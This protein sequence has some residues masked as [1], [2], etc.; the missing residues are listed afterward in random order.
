MNVINLQEN[1]ETPALPFKLKLANRANI[2][3]CFRDGKEHTVSE[4]SQMTGI[5]KITTMRAVQ[6]FCEKNVLVTGGK[7][8]QHNTGGKYPEIFR[9]NIRKNILSI[10]LWPG[11]ICLTL[12]DFSGQILYRRENNSVDTHHVSVQEIEAVLKEELRSFFEESKADRDLIY[13]VALSTAGIIDYRNKQ[14]RFNTQAPQW[15]KNISILDEIRPFF[16]EDTYFFLENGAK[17]MARAIL[18]RPGAAGKR[19]LLITTTW[20]IGGSMIQDGRVLNGRNSLIGEVGHMVVDAFDEEECNCGSRGCL[21]R[22]V[23]MKRVRERFSRMEVAP[24][25]PLAGMKPDEISEKL[26]FS[27]AD[28]GDPSARELVGYL[29]DCFAVALRNVSVTFD[30]EQ[31]Y[32]I[33]EYAD[34]G[35]YFDTRLKEKLSEFRYYGSEEP[36]ETFYEKMTMLEMNQMGVTVAITDHYFRNP[37][38]YEN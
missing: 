31:V 6:F 25:S 30:P 17:A 12:T 26:L 22:L 36:I 29:A 1:D 35:T 13:G 33:G 38:L 21:E 20:G 4:V 3:R 9:L 32:F 14:I 28:Q 8:Y 19:A 15:G 18:T 2:L 7:V 24:D 16:R 11:I 5:S 23:S 34:A 10:T 37:E 27:L